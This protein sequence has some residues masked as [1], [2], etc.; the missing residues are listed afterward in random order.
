MVLK[1]LGLNGV[2]FNSFGCED[3]DVRM[4][5]DGRSFAL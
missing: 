5:S 2:K 1:G 4:L 3:M